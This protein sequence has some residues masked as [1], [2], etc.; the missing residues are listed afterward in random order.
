MYQ[1]FG[2][3]VITALA[4]LLPKTSQL[5]N[6]PILP[7]EKVVEY[8]SYC[9]AICF[10]IL[11]HDEAHK[12]AVEEIV[13]ITE[14]LAPFLIYRSDKNVQETTAQTLY[15]ICLYDQFSLETLSNYLT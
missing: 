3:R 7:S 8:K 11:N 1:V 15:K 5:E 6:P 4:D 12:I 10:F 13:K 14:K 9:I 2:P